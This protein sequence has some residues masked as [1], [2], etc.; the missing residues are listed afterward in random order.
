M[1]NLIA[2]LVLTLI[3]SCALFGQNLTYSSIDPDDDR[4][5]DV[6][7]EDMDRMVQAYYDVEFRKTAIIYL[8]L[9]N[10]QTMNFT[11][12]Y[13]DYINLNRGFAQKRSELVKEYREEMKEDDRVKDE[14]NETAEFIENYWEINNQQQRAYTDLY[15]RLEDV[16]GPIKALQFFDLE[17]G[18]RSRLNRMVLERYAPTVAILEPNYV[19]YQNQLN[20]FNNWNSIN[21]DGEVGLDH[22]FTST[23]LEKLVNAAENMAMAE[24]IT[25]PGFAKKKKRIMEEASAITK[26]WKS[27]SHANSAKMAFTHTAELL[28]EIA[29]DSRF[30]VNEMTVKRLMEHAN[31]INVDK[32]LTD[33]SDTVY[34]F[35]NFAESLVNNLA[36]Q[37]FSGRS[38]YRHLGAMKMSTGTGD[39]DGK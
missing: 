33:Q 3:Y 35:F 29:K 22:N 11:P 15:D 18:A 38:T 39:A 28:S 36:R 31:A 16:V 32:K 27:M 24:G 1:K 20:D 23:G 8:G 26:D 7:M 10:D 14:R 12:I 2:T 30:S 34:A 21:I 13:L 19:T 25:V 5:K 9:D 6:T 37:A 4:M 17:R